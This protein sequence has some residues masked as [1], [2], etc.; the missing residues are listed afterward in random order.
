MILTAYHFRSLHS[1]Q[2]V[3]MPVTEYS[4][5]ERGASNT[6]SYQVF[7]KDSQGQ[8]MTGAKFNVEQFLIV[9]TNLSI[10]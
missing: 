4:A 1:S 7:I 5:E 9:R 3:R 8:Y 2:V 10:P 6:D